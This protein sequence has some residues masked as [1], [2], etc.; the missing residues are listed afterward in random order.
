MKRRPYIVKRTIALVLSFTLI[1]VTVLSV[2]AASYAAINENDKETVKSLVYTAFND[3][4]EAYYSDDYFRGDSM[5]Y[6]R[7]LSTF[8]YYVCNSSYETARGSVTNQSRNLEQLLEDNGFTHFEVNQDYKKEAS[9]DSSAVA[10]AYKTIRDGG[11]TYTL[12][13]I[14]PR[15]GTFKAE[16]ERSLYLS[17][18]G[19]DTGDHAGY[20]GCANKIIDFV[21]E[22]NKRNGIKG[23][24]KVYT[25]GYSGGAGVCDLFAAELIRHPKTVLGS[26]VKFDPSNLYCY[27]FSPL[28]IASLSSEPKNSKYDCIHNIYDKADLLMHLITAD[29]FDRYGTDYYYR[30]GVDKDMALALMKVDSPWIYRSY[31]GGAD[32]D[33][34]SPYKVDF[35]AMIKE[36]KLAMVPDDDSYLSKDME[37]Y[38]DS[39][40]REIQSICAQEGGGN[41]RKGY[42]NSFQEPTMHL[43]GYFFE[44]G[45]NFDHIQVLFGALS[46]TDTSIPLIL[47]MYTSFLVNKSINDN[48]VN[49]NALIEDSFNKL[50]AREEADGNS[51][52]GYDAFGKIRD[53]YFDRGEDGY[54][55]LKS[56]LSSSDKSLLLKGLKELTAKLY[57]ASV[58]TALEADG[59]DPEMVDL[60]T[61]DEDSKATSWLL[62]NIMFGNGD[63]SSELKPLNLENQQFKQLATF[64]SNTDRY[65]SLHMFYFVFSWI[66]AADPNFEDF[67][68][69]DEAQQTGYRRVFISASGGASVSGTVTDESNSVAATFKDGEIL[70]R[71]DEW[72]GMTTCDTG[73]WLRLPLDKSYKVSLTV[74]KDTSVDLKVADYSVREGEVKRVVTSD[75]SGSWT[76]LKAGTTENLVLDIPAA[77]CEHGLYDLTSAVYTLSRHN[78]KS[79]ADGG[80]SSG[81][82]RTISVPAVMSEI[83]SGDVPALRKVKAKASKKAFTVSWKKLSKKLRKKAGNIELQ[84]STDSQFSPE[85]TVT[86]TLGKSKKSLKVKK[87][88]KGTTYYVRVRSVKESGGSKYVSGW[89]K[90]KKVKVK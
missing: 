87:L 24:V 44:N 17:K 53:K 70:S 60:L 86:K 48:T 43:V 79:D 75:A 77:N 33:L 27:N 31:V 82:I 45:I 30:D 63:Q 71:N 29:K 22:Y 9:M 62:A 8:S 67:T 64:A 28:R 16:F 56:Q 55:R 6:N 49:L 68:K 84:Y 18:S 54:Y 74:S 12:L 38:L 83:V 69:P 41:S 36:G 4:D 5:A 72:I 85:S 10:C 39:V 35:E 37:G 90:I 2:P 34:Y 23:D 20:L 58:R 50:V 7:K 59:E 88:T 66:R 14:I 47:S 52:T 13:A 57:A 89:S 11:K 19:N 78:N 51:S 76:G 32:P 25:T 40:S 3:P 81:N 65:T 21:G 26:R 1:A 80:K 42:Y 73:N 46:S 61:S 15:S